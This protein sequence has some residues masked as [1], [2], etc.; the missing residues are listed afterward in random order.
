MAKD[1]GLY[2]IPKMNSETSIFLNPG[3]ASG[4]EIQ[5]RPLGSYTRT[6]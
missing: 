3:I 5:T 4:P 6:T 1:H 2:M